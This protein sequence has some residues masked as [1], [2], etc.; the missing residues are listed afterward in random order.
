MSIAVTEMAPPPSYP[1]MRRRL[2]PPPE[3]R[4]QKDEETRWRHIGT[5][6]N[7]NLLT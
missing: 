5:T 1:T 4:E 3:E 2:S 6:A 7:Q